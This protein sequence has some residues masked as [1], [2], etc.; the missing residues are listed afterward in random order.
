MTEEQVT[1]YLKNRGFPE[2]V[3]KGSGAGLIKRWKDFVVEVEQGYCPECLIDD[4][5]SD[6]E[7][8]ELIHEIGRDD[9]VK[10]ADERFRAMFTAT[11]IKHYYRERKSD[12]DFWNYGYPENATGFF[13]EQIKRHILQQA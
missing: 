7:L 4:Y 2:H 10:E 3:W 13:Y 11:H 8:R 5:W 12:Y 9:R 1:D 6:L